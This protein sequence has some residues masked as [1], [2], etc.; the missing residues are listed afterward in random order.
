MLLGG[1][2]VI[3]T[4]VMPGQFRTL[5]IFSSSSEKWNIIHPWG[6]QLADNGSGPALSAT[7]GDQGRGTAPY[8][9]PQLYISGIYYIC[10]VLKVVQPYIQ[11]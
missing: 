7:P 5:A 10:C 11:F 4:I 8:I 9:Q 1:I 3:L 2:Q 6:R